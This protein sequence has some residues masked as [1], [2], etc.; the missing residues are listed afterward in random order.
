MRAAA[1]GWRVSRC[2]AYGRLMSVGFQKAVCQGCRMAERR[3]SK[4]LVVKD[5]KYVYLIE[6][7]TAQVDFSWRD[8]SASSGKMSYYYVRGEQDKF[9]LLTLNPGHFNSSI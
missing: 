1:D 5:G 3:R 9:W 2:K 4:V 6:P 8:M 7:K